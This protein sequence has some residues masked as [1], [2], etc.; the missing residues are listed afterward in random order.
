M[1]TIVD[2]VV[3]VERVPP[4]K[5]GIGHSHMGKHVLTDKLV[6]FSEYSVCVGLRR[7]VDN[8][9]VYQVVLE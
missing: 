1:K 5:H 9:Q 6:Y 8:E 3:E 7:R 2:L 4:E